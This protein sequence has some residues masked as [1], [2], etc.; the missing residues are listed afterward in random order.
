[1]GPS[2][3]NIY[4]NYLYDMINHS[5]C[6]PLADDHEV[7]GGINLHNDCLLLRSDICCFHGW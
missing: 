4:I 5:R 3:F 2:I 6:V 1:V 7:Y